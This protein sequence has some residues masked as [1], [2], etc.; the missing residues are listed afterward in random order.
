M[1]VAGAAALVLGCW[2]ASAQAVKI[3]EYPASPTA[4]RRFGITAG[5]DGNLWF[6]NFDARK[7]GRVTPAGA[8]TEYPAGAGTTDGS[9]YGITA[10]PDGNL[11]FTDYGAH[12]IGRITPA[13]V[14]TEYPAGTGTSY[15]SVSGIATGPDGNLWFTDSLARNIGRVTTDS[16]APATGNLLRN[17][18]AEFG[19]PAPSDA[20][21][22]PVLGWAA[23]PNFTTVASSAP[24]SL[25]PAPSGGALFAAGP[26]DAFSQAIQDVAVSARAAAIDTH[27]ATAGLAGQ[28][29]GQGSE[30]DAP[31]LSARFLD[32]KYNPLG[33]IAIPPLLAA[34]RG[35]VTGFVARRT[36]GLVPARTRTIEVVALGQRTD[37]N[38]NDAYFD[39]LS[40]TLKITPLPAPV[41][42]ALKL[43][44]ASFPA[45][46]A[47]ASV[48]KRKTGTTVSYRDSLA[49]RTRF[50]VLRPAPGRKVGGRCV[51]PTKHNNHAKR[52]KRLVALGGFSHT[53][54]LGK[55]R[56]H[57]SGRVGPKKLSPGNYRL[58]A[59]PRN[60]EGRLGKAVARSF[61]IER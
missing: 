52:C 29:G 55:N 2:C 20:V 51:K 21:T 14:I 46:A 5:P 15:G 54:V 43:S 56:F 30:N 8:I 59:I 58:R 61:A 45:A 11:W 53:D 57:F 41:I 34:D 7:I 13:G 27:R 1:L 60:V 6:T 36:S 38:Y 9:P 10:G 12:K 17:P 3:I 22:A 44:P 24:A 42:A 50:T 18:G 49:G 48:A 26:N 28:L 40:L 4:G 37:G 35:G 32:A 33:S 25:P 47:G 31:S 16:P 19:M 23:M 39:N